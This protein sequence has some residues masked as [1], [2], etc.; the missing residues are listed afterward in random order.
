MTYNA[1]DDWPVY[2]DEPDRDLYDDDPPL[3]VGDTRSYSID[4]PTPDPDVMDAIRTA[5]LP[6]S[7]RRRAREFDDPSGSPYQPRHPNMK[8]GTYAL[9][10]DSATLSY[11]SNDVDSVTWT[12]DPYG[13]VTATVTLVNGS[14]IELPD[15]QAFARL[16]DSDV[17][18][19]EVRAGLTGA[20][21]TG[22]DS[23]SGYAVHGVLTETTGDG[24][25]ARITIEVTDDDLARLLDGETLTR[26]APHEPKKTT[27][28]PEPDSGKPRVTIG[29]NL[30]EV[31]VGKYELHA[32]DA[33]GR[34]EFTDPD[35]D[36]RVEVV[37]V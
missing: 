27:V 3:W 5:S 35:R 29:K 28:V 32:L 17:D 21:A 36:V 23:G 20:E 33:G 30:I 22:S 8:C 18:I 25:I 10:V 4:Q 37:T 1:D 26:D 15:E 11:D 19:G 12:G 14:V 31:G 7:A 6:Y 24:S 9:D 16:F 13:T 2:Y 34:T